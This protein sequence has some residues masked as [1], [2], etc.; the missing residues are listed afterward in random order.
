TRLRTDSSLPVS[1]A[2]ARTL[3]PD[4]A[5]SS[6][7]A[8]SSASPPRAARTMSTPSPAS[9]R[10][11]ALPMP[12]LPPVTIARLLVSS[13]SMATSNAGQAGA[14]GVLFGRIA[15]E[16]VT[17]ARLSPLTNENMSPDQRVVADA[18]RSGPRGGLRGPFE[19]WLRAPELCDR[20][21]KLGEYCRF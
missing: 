5:A 21:Q 11:I 20:A 2:T 7:A 8:A 6:F 19:A 15:T 3:R 13:R 14:D 1:V 12:R 9:W 4:S 16:D 18:I 17:M 10:A